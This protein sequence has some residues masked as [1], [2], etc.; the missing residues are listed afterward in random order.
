MQSTA[1]SAVTVVDGPP[2]VSNVRATVP[3]ALVLIDVIRWPV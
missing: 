2:P 1:W 3:S